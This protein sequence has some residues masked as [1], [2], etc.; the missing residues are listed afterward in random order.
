MS[1]HCQPGN[2][3]HGH[4]REG[5]RQVAQ[6]HEDQGGDDQA[7][8]QRAHPLVGV[9]RL[10]RHRCQVFDE[11]G[12]E[13]GGLDFVDEPRDRWVDRQRDPGPFRG[14]VDGGVDAVKVVEPPLDPRRAGATGH[15]ADAE[16]DH[17]VGGEGTLG[18]LGISHLGVGHGMGF[19]SVR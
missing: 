1:S 10:V 5:D 19:R 9:V 17:S 16:R 12:A 6:G 13:P 8:A 11:L 4:Q 15:A 2:R 18:H 7:L 3:S 14:V